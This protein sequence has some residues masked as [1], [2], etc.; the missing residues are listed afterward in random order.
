VVPKFFHEISPAEATYSAISETAYRIHLF[1]KKHHTLPSSLR[2]LPERSGYLNRTLDHWNQP[3][4]YRVS[5][6]GTVKVGSYGKDGAPGGTGENKDMFEIFRYR[7]ATGRFLA[8]DDL[9]IVESVLSR[10]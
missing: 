10:E 4:L 6:D 1:A 3:L 5:D 8:A 9:W 7:D 2:D